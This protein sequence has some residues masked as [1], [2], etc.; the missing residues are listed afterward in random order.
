MS[1]VEASVEFVSP[2]QAERAIIAHLKKRLK[3]YG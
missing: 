3:P 2:V 1:E